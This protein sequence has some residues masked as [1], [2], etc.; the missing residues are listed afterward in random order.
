MGAP[1]PGMVSSLAVSVG[2]KVEKD[3]KLLTIEA[4][5]MQT[6]VY[7]P[8]AGAV[9]EVLTQVGDSVQSKDLLICLRAALS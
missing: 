2:M 3:A 1:I 6:T 9:E 8:F 4:M 7:A 5:K